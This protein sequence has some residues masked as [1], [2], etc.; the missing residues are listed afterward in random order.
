MI[1]C[2]KKSFYDLE[3]NNIMEVANLSPL[4]FSND[5]QLVICSSNSLTEGLRHPFSFQNARV[6]Q[7]NFAEINTINEL[8]KIKKLDFDNIGENIDAG[9]PFLSKD[10]KTLYFSSTGKGLDINYGGYDIYYSVF[11]NGRWSNPVNLGPEINSH[12]HEISPFIDGLGT[13]FFS[14]DG[15]KG[16]GGFDIFRAEKTGDKWN[17]LRNIGYGVNSSQDDQY[18]IYDYEHEVAY[19]ASNRDEGLGSY[20]LYSA[21]KIGDLSLMPKVNEEIIIKTIEENKNSSLSKLTKDQE[22][23]TIL[24]SN[25]AT[26]LPSVDI[27]KELG[28][29]DV[30]NDTKTQNQGNLN[31]LPQAENVYIGVIKDAENKERLED[32]WLYVKNRKTGEERKLKT[33]KYGEYSLILDPETD[34]D[35]NCSKVGYINFTFEINTGDGER[36]TLLGEREMKRIATQNKTENTSKEPINGENFLRGPQKGIAVPK[37]V[38]QIQVGV[39]KNINPALIKEISK[40][41]NVIKEPYKDGQAKIYRLGNFADETHA[42]E[43]LVQVQSMMGL[44]KSFIKKIE[45]LQKNAA[46]KMNFEILLVYPKTNIIQ[47]QYSDSNKTEV[48]IV[49]KKDTKPEKILNNDKDE[50]KL[51]FKIQLG[52]FKDPNKANLPELK[53]I[54][55]IEKILMPETGL[56]FFY[57]KG[58]KSLDEARASLKKA[59]EKG[60]DQP[61]IVAFQNGKKVQLDKLKK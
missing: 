48:K 50:D 49:E 42:K 8:P 44:E 10:G 34:F 20:D 59:K 11:E 28:K 2:F 55:E 41:A 26:N 29:T 30:I 24:P 51:E 46:D 15:H 39:F 7:L 60:I 38:F 37:S 47:K 21:L 43:V 57:L 35:F 32:V 31:K 33:S 25:K 40:L 36:R 56:T 23:K 4:I 17:D 3:T 16:F 52:A 14:S 53:D 12:G 19:F 18:F 1:H 6:F 54:G 13:L 61:F 27:S 9:F 5:K 58:Y 22:V 45:P